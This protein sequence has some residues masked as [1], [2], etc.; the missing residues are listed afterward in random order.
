MLTG[1]GTSTQALAH[2]AQ[3][4]TVETPNV[5]EVTNITTDKPIVEIEVGELYILRYTILPTNATDKSVYIDL[6]YAQDVVEVEEDEDDKSLMMIRG[7]LHGTGVVSIITNN[8]K[9]VSYSVTVTATQP[10]PPIEPLVYEA[11]DVVEYYNGCTPYEPVIYVETEDYVGWKAQ[12]NY[13][14]SSDDSKYTLVEPLLDIVD[15]LPLIYNP[16]INGFLICNK[17]DYQPATEDSIAHYRYVAV[18]SNHFAAVTV[19]VYISENELML[20]LL[21]YDGRGGL[22]EEL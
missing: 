6:T 20:D 7:K 22:Y 1:C 21:I 19:F 12:Y 9:F 8:G 3:N 10:E 14:A 16:L 17:N 13:G 15:Y 18:S 4:T 2:E 5:V 11:E